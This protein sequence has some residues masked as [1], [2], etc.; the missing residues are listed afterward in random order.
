MRKEGKKSYKFFKIIFVVLL[1]FHQK[2]VEEE[3][4]EI[5]AAKI[6]LA[7]FAN[8]N[9]NSAILKTLELRMIPICDSINRYI[10]DLPHS[11]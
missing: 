6:V 8:N 5:E 7:L 3:S 11:L 4:F 2:L 10:K 1:Q 9:L